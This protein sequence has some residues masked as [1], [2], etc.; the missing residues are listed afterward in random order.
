MTV[1]DNFNKIEKLQSKFSQLVD[2]LHLLRN[3][4]ANFKSA[5]SE[6]MKRVITEVNKSKK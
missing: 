6:D 5:V 1:K 2:E 3:D 4:I